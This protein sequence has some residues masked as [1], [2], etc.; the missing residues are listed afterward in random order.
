MSLAFKRLKVYVRVSLVFLLGAAI[1]LVLFMNR[2][3]KV[4][5]W[6]FWIRD[7]DEQVNVVWLI[8]WTAVATL[9]SWWVFAFGWGLWRDM[10]EVKRAE[11][12]KRA[13]GRLAERE[14]E[15]DERERRIDRKVKEAI[16]SEEQHGE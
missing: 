15:I 13:E 5:F 3:N 9:V 1:V 12:S 4:A 14:A 7:K 10:R 8:L 16:A 11:A 6:F 2:A